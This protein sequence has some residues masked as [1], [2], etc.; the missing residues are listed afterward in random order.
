MFLIKIYSNYFSVPVES[1]KYVNLHEPFHREKW[2]YKGNIFVASG[3][4]I[5]TAFAIN[6]MSNVT[7]KNKQKYSKNQKQIFPNI[8]KYFYRNINA[9]FHQYKQTFASH[10]TIFFIGNFVITFQQ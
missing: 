6:V 3:R 7:I 9:N 4:W 2:R 5:S 8:I 10:V 1:L